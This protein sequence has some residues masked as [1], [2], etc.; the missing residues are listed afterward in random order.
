[1][2]LHSLPSFPTDYFFFK[3]LLLH[4]CLIRTDCI[5]YK[6]SSLTWWFISIFN[7][8]YRWF[9]FTTL[10]NL[11]ISFTLLQHLV[12]SNITLY[13][14]TNDNCILLYW[15]SHELIKVLKKARNSTDRCTRNAL[16]LQWLYVAVVTLHSPTLLPPFNYARTTF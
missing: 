10:S 5:W 6:V 16:G 3:S 12:K 2:T 9:N 14:E 4:S 15:T 1:M 8:F 11:V 7:P 13:M